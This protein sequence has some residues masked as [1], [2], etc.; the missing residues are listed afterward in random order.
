MPDSGVGWFLRLVA[1][2]DKR[3]VLFTALTTYN[4]GY[5][6]QASWTPAHGNECFATTLPTP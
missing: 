4:S 5:P 2:Q 6:L 3:A 1:A